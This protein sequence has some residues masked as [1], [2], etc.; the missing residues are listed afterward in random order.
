M[1]HLHSNET[2]KSFILPKEARSLLRVIERGMRAGRVRW[3]YAN[4][5]CDVNGWG[6]QLAITDWVRPGQLYI[7]NE[8]R[9]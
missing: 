6:V 5:W 3:N 9:R 8:N 1:I 2:S 4:F 7:N